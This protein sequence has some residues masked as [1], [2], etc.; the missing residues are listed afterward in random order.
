MPKSSA[1]W[2]C[3]SAAGACS[4]CTHQ[5]K[6]LGWAPKPGPHQGSACRRRSFRRIGTPGTAPCQPSHPT[7]S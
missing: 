3:L 5:E 1:D 4:T 7:Y 2:W 6:E